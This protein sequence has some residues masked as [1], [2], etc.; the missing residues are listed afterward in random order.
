MSLCGV[1]KHQPTVDAPPMVTTPRIVV[2]EHNASNS[3]RR[4]LRRCST[5]AS[6]LAKCPI[7][8]ACLRMDTGYSALKRPHS[9]RPECVSHDQWSVPCYHRYELLRIH[10][11]STSRV[12][13]NTLVVIA[14]RGHD[15]LICSA[16]V[17]YKT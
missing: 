15:Q 3:T 12:N 6:S 9:S 8:P 11:N 1:A 2:F 16:R 5:V 14:Y 10:L 13:L 4:A 17:G 7:S